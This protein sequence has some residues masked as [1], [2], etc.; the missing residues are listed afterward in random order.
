MHKTARQGTESK[1]TAQQ[2]L[3]SDEIC[4][5]GAV[6]LASLIRR[7]E[8]SARDLMRAHLRQIEVVIRGSTPL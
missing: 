2:R 3:T 1:I 7:K 4:F 8:L 6:E 5:R